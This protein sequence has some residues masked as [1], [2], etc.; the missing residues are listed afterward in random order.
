MLNAPQQRYLKDTDTLMTAQSDRSPFHDNP[1]Q[2]RNIMTGIP[3]GEGIKVDDAKAVGDRMMSEMT[4]QS[5]LSYSFKRRQQA[6]TALSQSPSPIRHHRT[7]RR[8]AICIRWC[9]IIA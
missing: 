3:A 9:G 4:G 2:L 7:N 5:V 8:H 6:I 1:P